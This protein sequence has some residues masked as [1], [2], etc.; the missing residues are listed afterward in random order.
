MQQNR[1]RVSR[2]F[3]L[4]PFPCLLLFIQPSQAFTQITTENIYEMSVDSKAE[5]VIQQ[6]R[7]EV[8]KVMFDPKCDK[9]WIGGLTNVF[10]LSSGLL[11]EGSRVNR[12]G[13]FLGRQYSARMLVVAAEP[14][15]SLKISSDEPFELT[16]T[17]DLEDV[18]GGT[19]VKLRVQGVVEDQYRVPPAVLAKSLTEA[20]NEDLKKLKRHFEVQTD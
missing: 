15:R 7:S 3:A 20:L 6:P 11:K 10:P 9:N 8:A 12:D 18:D 17:Y 4:H 16:T 1:E 2:N 13:S 5:I 19:K 14:E